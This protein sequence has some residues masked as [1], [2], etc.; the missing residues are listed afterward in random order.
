[1]ASFLALADNE[2]WLV[3][4]SNE[5]VHPFNFGDDQARIKFEQIDAQVFGGKDPDDAVA[6]QLAIGP[7]GEG[8]CEA[9]R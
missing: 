5:A 9:R 6:F 4:G 2:D 3:S 1:V 7:A 8:N